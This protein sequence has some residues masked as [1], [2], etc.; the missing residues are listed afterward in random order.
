MITPRIRRTKNFAAYLSAV[1]QDISRIESKPR[2]SGVADGI[3]GGS[4]LS[5]S[6]VLE[7]NFIHSSNYL[8][9]FTG[10]KIDSNGVAEFGSVFVRWCADS[11]RVPPAFRGQ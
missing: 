6:V 2:V 10:W 5:S 3:I 4:S 1:N 9:G 7:N 8:P 11:A